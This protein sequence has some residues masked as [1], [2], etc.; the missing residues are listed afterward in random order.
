MERDGICRNVLRDTV[1]LK[2]L[3][4]KGKKLLK[5]DK[6]QKIRILEQHASSLI[7]RKELERQVQQ[8]LNARNC[9]KQRVKG[10]N[11]LSVF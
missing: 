9:K 8:L 5:A 11:L 3:T 1:I 7:S 2:I 6:F 10:Q 4:E